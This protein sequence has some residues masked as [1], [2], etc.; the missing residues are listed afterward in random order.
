M[1]SL[2]LV[3]HVVIAV[4]LV[5]LVLMQHGKGADVGAAFGSGASNTMFGSVGTTPFLM[6]ITVAFTI[7]FFATS[8]GLSYLSAREQRLQGATAIP[9]AP[10][11]PSTAPMTVP[12]P[13]SSQPNGS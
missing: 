8:I 13:P 6:K 9:V 2:I 3:I 11:V 1:Q 7:I 12:P 5:V 10:M 4:C